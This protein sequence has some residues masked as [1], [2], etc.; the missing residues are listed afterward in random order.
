[1]HKQYKTLTELFTSQIEKDGYI[2]F[3]DA[4]SNERII[5]FADFGEEVLNCL[6]YLQGQ[7]LMPG[8]ELVINTRSNFFNTIPLL[9]LFLSTKLCTACC[10]TWCGAC[11]MC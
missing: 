4:K 2:R 3:I 11:Y 6:G 7:N 1:M 8:D 10:C 9:W 5:R